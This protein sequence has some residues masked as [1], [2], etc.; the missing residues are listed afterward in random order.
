V[1]HCRKDP[2]PEDKLEAAEELEWGIVDNDDVDTDTAEA[3]VLGNIGKKRPHFNF[4]QV[5][6]C[7]I[8][9]SHWFL[10][11]WKWALD[12]RLFWK[13]TKQFAQ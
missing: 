7:N 11:R 1:F 4:T 6:F 2:K 10:G 3:I 9:I 13:D 12:A 8:P 5:P